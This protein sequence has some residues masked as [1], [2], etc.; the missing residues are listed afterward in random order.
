MEVLGRKEVSFIHNRHN[1]IDDPAEL[2]IIKTY[3][4]G[5]YNVDQDQQAIG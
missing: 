2:I 4:K 3:E 1:I 5:L